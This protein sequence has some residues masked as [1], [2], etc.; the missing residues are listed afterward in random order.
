[1]VIEGQKIIFKD[2]D[3]IGYKF[4]KADFICLCGKHY[5]TGRG[6]GN[7]WKKEGFKKE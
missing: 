5:K 7:H 2:S 4:A 6:L 1:M 3:T